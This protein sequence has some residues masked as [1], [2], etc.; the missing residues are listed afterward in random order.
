MKSLIRLALLSLM[1]SLLWA[2]LAS[3]SLPIK[4]VYQGSASGYTGIVLAGQ[5][6]GGAS[7]YRIEYEIMKLDV[8]TGAALSTYSSYSTIVTNPTYGLYRTTMYL[9]IGWYDVVVRAFNIGTGYPETPNRVR[10]GVGDVYI[11]A[12]QSNAQG[13]PESGTWSLPSLTTYDGILS[14]DLNGSCNP[15]LPE[16]P[17]MSSLNG[18]NRIAPSGNNSWYWLKLG[19]DLQTGFP[20]G[21]I[22]IAFFNASAGGST[23]VNWKESAAG[24]N[25]IND[26]TLAKWCG[27]GYSGTAQPYFD[28]K[29]SLKFYAS[30]FGVKAVLW[31]QG[32]G[33][34]NADRSKFT[35]RINYRTNLS[36]V[37]DKSR[38]DFSSSLRWLVS[39]ASYQG[40][41]PSYMGSPPAVS[42][43][44]TLAQNDVVIPPIDGTDI[45]FKGVITDGLGNGYREATDKVHFREDRTNAL[46]LVGG[47]WKTKIASPSGSYSVIAAT[48]SPTISMTKSGS[49]WTLTVPSGYPEYRW[50]NMTSPNTNTGSGTNILTGTGSG[51]YACLV[52]NVNG[53]WNVTQTVYT[54]GCP[55]CREGLVEG[56]EE[57]NEEELGI[58]TKAY[59]VPFVKDFTIEFTIPTESMIRLELVDIKGSVVK[60]LVENI[61]SKGTYKYPVNGSNISNGVLFYMLYVNDLAITKKVVKVN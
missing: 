38:T 40:N 53:N 41:N 1:P 27:T 11:V 34:N 2:Q 36:S 58:S 12:G 37:I 49:S 55:G 50:M 44:V 14:H 6:L 28:F 23:S 5:Y 16:Y 21:G 22:P 7:D 56:R 10:F 26:Y 15:G 8:N 3:I 18:Y 45:S 42:S 54:T 32:E 43:D 13:Y 52:R 17:V 20:S 61:H 48:S 46:T 30:I 57:W 47:L 9:P 19:Q 39:E 59:P 33:D 31:H 60:K 24:S 35:T 4:G 29:N 25:T 51:R